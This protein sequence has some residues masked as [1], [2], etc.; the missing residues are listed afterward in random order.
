MVEYN[1]VV[2]IPATGASVLQPPGLGKFRPGLYHGVVR[3]GQVLNEGS[4]VANALGGGGA[5]SRLSEGGRKGRCGLRRCCGILGGQSGG[6]SRSYWNEG[7]L[8]A[9]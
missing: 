6:F 2:S 4:P 7:G 8:D 1:R 5:G 9:G 3:I